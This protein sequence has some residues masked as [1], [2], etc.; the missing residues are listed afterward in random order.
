MNVKDFQEIVDASE[1]LTDI[2]EYAIRK[3]KSSQNYI[4]VDTLGDFIVL[5]AHVVDDICS[6]LWTDSTKDKLN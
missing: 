3:Y 1:P 6:A 5:E 2:G 4:L